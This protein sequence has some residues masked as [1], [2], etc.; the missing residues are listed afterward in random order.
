MARPDV[1]IREQGHSNRHTAWCY[2]PECSWTYSNSAKTD[3][4]QQAT[5]HRQKHRKE[6]SGG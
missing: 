5:W 3:V 6:E 4:Y 1:R 2:E